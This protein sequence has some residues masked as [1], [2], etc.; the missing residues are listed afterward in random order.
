MLLDYEVKEARIVDCPADAY[1]VTRLGALEEV[2]PEAVYKLGL[3]L[4]LGGIGANCP[5]WPPSFPLTPIPGEATSDDEEQL[6]LVVKDLDLEHRGYDDLVLDA[7]R[8]LVHPWFHPLSQAYAYALKI[9]GV[10]DREMIEKIHEL[11]T[12]GEPC[13]T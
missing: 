11:V 8:L 1:G 5:N 3:I 12:E 2:T 4:L 9:N 7:F 13:S 6:A 10:I